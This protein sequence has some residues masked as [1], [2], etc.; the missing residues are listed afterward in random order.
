MLGEDLADEAEV[1]ASHDVAAAV[2]RRDPR[3]FLAA[4]LERV[5]REESQARHRVPWGVDPKDA[6]FVARTVARFWAA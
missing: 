4:V 1:A 3:R 2:R 5:E 6:A